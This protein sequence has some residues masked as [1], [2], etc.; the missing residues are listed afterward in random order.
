MKVILSID[1]VRFPLTGIGRYTF[2]L[3]KKLQNA[4]NIDELKFLSGKNF[5]L[6]LPL[7]SEQAGQQHKLK[8][9]VQSSY[10]ASEAYRILMPHLKAMTLR[11]HE[12][13]LFHGPNF[14]LPPFHGP[15]IATFHDLSPFT[16]SQ[17]NTPQR[18]RFLQ[19]EL[20]KT[21]KTADALITDSEFTR[22]ELAGYFSWPIEK[23]HTVP[24]A[25]GPEFHPRSAR[26]VEKCLNQ[27][28]LTY[29]NYSLFV[30]TIEPRKN[31]LNLLNAY[32]M[33]PTSLKQRYPLILAMARS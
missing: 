31:I 8:Q 32:S 19:K 16:W 6:E 27:Y 4:Q 12:D 13:F 10:I 7:I 26:E 22:Q 24:L 20:Q 25:C 14:F 18:I 5:L 9:I 33:L 17:C 3:A 23:I 28:G 15:K 29:K 2:E 21:L 1:S 11:G 30:G